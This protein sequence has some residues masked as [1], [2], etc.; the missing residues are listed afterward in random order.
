MK[1][2]QLYS[3]H[4]SSFSETSGESSMAMVVRIAH[5]DMDNSL[6]AVARIEVDNCFLY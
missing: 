6:Q 4:C 1:Q 5:F 2:C 3:S